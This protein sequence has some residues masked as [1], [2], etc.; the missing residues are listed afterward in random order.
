MGSNLNSIP[1]GFQL[2]TRNLNLLDL[3][4]ESNQP[5]QNSND[6]MLSAVSGVFSPENPW[7]PFSDD[8]LVN[9]DFNL[10]PWES[11]QGSDQNELGLSESMRVQRTA[12]NALVDNTSN[13]FSS[14]QTPSNK[15]ALLRDRGQPKTNKRSRNASKSDD[16]DAFLSTTDNES[17]TSKRLR[18]ITGRVTAQTSQILSADL[19]DEESRLARQQSLWEHLS[20][21]MNS[22]QLQSDLKLNVEDYLN[23]IQVTAKQH[24]DKKGLLDNLNRLKGFVDAAPKNSEVASTRRQVDH[25]ILLLDLELWKADPNARGNKTEAA[26]KIIEAFDTNSSSLL[27]DNLGINLLPDCIGLLS[28]LTDFNLGNNELEELPSSIGKLT[29]LQ[30]LWISGNRFKVVPP[31]LKNLINLNKLALSSNQIAV[32]PSFLE[33][34]INLEELYLRENKIEELPPFIENLTQ[35]QLLF[36]SGNLIKILPEFLGNLRNLRFL[37]VNHNKIAVLPSFLGNLI[38]LKNLGLCNNEI[39]VLP[40]SLGNLRNLRSLDLSMNKIEVLPPSLGNL[41]DLTELNLGNNNIEVLPPSFGNLR[42]LKKV[43]LSKNK[44]KEL[45]SYFGNYD[46]LEE[47]HLDNNPGLCAIPMCLANSKSL[48]VLSVSETGISA[49]QK[50][51]IFQQQ[52]SEANAS[53]EE[54]G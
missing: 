48:D 33:N 19:M 18:S 41:N 8:D 24:P 53:E 30:V 54:S 11:A 29:Q 2:T 38:N 32:L 5:T 1:S 36:L 45:P 26:D 52:A 37:I 47:L 31:I 22:P 20:T 17:M 35:L 9:T 25:K 23:I 12:Q 27:L 4:Q 44:I 46:H 42:K 43:D 50:E 49:D 40:P 6:R 3:S 13:S 34:L 15:P 7:V 14:A 39:A 21:A 10:F 16:E 51:T 28:S